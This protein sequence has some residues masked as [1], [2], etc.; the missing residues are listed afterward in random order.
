MRYEDALRSIGLLV[1][2]IGWHE[3]VLIQTSLGFHLKGVSRDAPIDRLIDSAALRDLL[4]ELP[5]GREQRESPRR[6]LWPR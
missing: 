6:R 1:D 2:R 5:K 4:N 3:I